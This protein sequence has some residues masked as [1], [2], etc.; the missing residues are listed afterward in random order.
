LLKLREEINMVGNGNCSVYAIMSQLYP[1]AYGGYRL[2]GDKK[3]SEG[4]KTITTDV[5]VQ[6]KV[7]EIRKVAIDKLCENNPE[8]FVRYDNI[9]E[10]LNDKPSPGYC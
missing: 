3:N 2:R 10:V 6:A 8:D 1:Q 5:N 7:K 4:N 9:E